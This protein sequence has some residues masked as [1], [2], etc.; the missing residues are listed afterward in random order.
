MSLLQI[1][2]SPSGSNWKVHSPNIENFES[3]FYALKEDAKSFAFSKGRSI[4]EAKNRTV[5]VLVQ[6]MDGTIEERRT[7]GDDPNPP[8][9]KN[10]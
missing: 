1:W 10:K 3:K 8:K 2:V 5:E 6:K 4:S 9:D 7:Y